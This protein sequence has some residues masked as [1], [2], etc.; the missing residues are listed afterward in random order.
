MPSW[1]TIGRAA[2]SPV[3]IISI[4]ITAFKMRLFD[5]S[6][7]SHETRFPCKPALASMSLDRIIFAG[8]G[9]A[10][11]TLFRPASALAAASSGARLM[12]RR[13]PRSMAHSRPYR[14]DLNFSLV[15]SSR[16]CRLIECIS[17]TTPL[18]SGSHFREPYHDAPNLRF[19]PFAV[20]IC[21]PLPC[22]HQCH[23]PN[24]CHIRP[25][26]AIR[27]LCI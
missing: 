11:F 20:I 16:A 23:L 1:L 19:R 2:R 8:E 21:R 7:I 25:D 13:R 22:R 17:S 10:I 12:S 26:G 15:S 5:T 14:L 4:A 18:S 9:S 27:S 24:P 3:Q 6:G